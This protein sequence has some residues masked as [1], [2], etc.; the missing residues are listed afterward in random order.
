MHYFHIKTFTNVNYYNFKYI[1]VI[2]FVIQ[3]NIP[4]FYLIKIRIKSFIGSAP[5]DKEKEKSR[6]AKEKAKEKEKDKE[7]DS[8]KGKEKAKA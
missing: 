4:P 2:D 5:V 6:T 1:I 3:K 8:E 7:K